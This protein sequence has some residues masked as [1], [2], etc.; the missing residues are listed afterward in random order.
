MK[1]LTIRSITFV[2][3]VG[4]AATADSQS[5]AGRWILQITNPDQ[6][7]ASS[8]TVRFS[9][10]AAS[11]C[12]TGKWK[13]VVVEKIG[14]TSADFFPV[15]DPLSYMIEGSELTIG[16]N[17]VCD[18]YLHLRGTI[19]NEGAKGSYGGFGI[20]SGKSLGAFTLTPDR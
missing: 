19:T 11:S 6:S 13:R 5:L 4:F 10:D 3:G 18:A 1:S 14:S 12:M 2:V 15:A 17:E 7:A 20:N 16:R 8:L 9:E